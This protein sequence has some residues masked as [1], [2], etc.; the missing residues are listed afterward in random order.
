MNEKLI[1]ELKDSNLVDETE[2]YRL[3]VRAAA[4][5]EAADAKMHEQ[6]LRIA[7]LVAHLNAE[8]AKVARLVAEIERLK[9]DFDAAVADIKH[10]DNCDV[11][12][13]TKYDGACDESDFDCKTCKNTCPCATCRNERNCESTERRTEMNADETVRGLRY[14]QKKYENKVILTGETDVSAMCRDS[15]D[16]IESLQAQLAESQRRERAA[17]ADIVVAHDAG[18]CETC[19]HKAVEAGASCKKWP[20]RS[21]FEWRG[22]QEAGKGETE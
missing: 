14:T 19:K 18:K 15:A 10:N 21:C 17:V 4:A 6:D 1:A 7:D 3:C 8:Q 22:P 16:L 13:Y 5:L 12:K 2:K 20:D 11:C 9:T